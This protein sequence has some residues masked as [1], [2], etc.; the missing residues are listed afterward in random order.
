MGNCRAPRGG[1]V[2]YKFPISSWKLELHHWPH[3]LSIVLGRNRLNLFILKTIAAKYWRPNHHIGS[4]LLSSRNCPLRKVSAHRSVTQ[5]QNLIKLKKVC[6]FE[7]ILKSHLLFFFPCV[8]SKEE[9]NDCSIWARRQRFSPSFSDTS[10]MSTRKDNNIVQI[11]KWFCLVNPRHSGTVALGYTWERSTASLTGWAHAS[12]PGWCQMRR[13][14]LT[15]PAGSYSCYA[16]SLILE[17]V[18]FLNFCQTVKWAIFSWVLDICVF[19]PVKCSSLTFI[20]FSIGDL[21]FS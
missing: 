6:L 13:C 20:Q 14:P 3:T 10:L 1:H 7:H 17:I 11:W 8:C 19:S 16:S 5:G 12:L 18:R 15:L 21:P 4:V 2:S 9:H